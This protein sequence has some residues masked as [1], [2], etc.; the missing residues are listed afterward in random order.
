MAIYYTYTDESPAIATH[1]LLP[2]I[3]AFLRSENIE[4][5]TADISLASRV[6]ANFSEYLSEAQKT[7]DDLAFLANLTKSSDANIIK[8]P[9]ISASLPQLKACISELQARGY[10]LPNY[11]DNAQS[12]EEKSIKARYAKVLGSAVNPVLREGNSDRRAAKSVKDYARANPVWSAQWSGSE[13]T[14]VASMSGGDFYASEKSKI[15]ANSTNLSINFTPNGGEKTCLKTL[16]IEAG[17][18]VDSAFMSVSEL[19]NF[20]AASAQ[21]AKESGLVYSAHLKATM[22]K[23][24]D[25]VIFGRFVSV[26]FGGVFAEF[27]DEFK[28]L[29]INANDGLKAVFEKIKNSPNFAQIKDRFDEAFA[30]LP[31]IY[32]ID[33]NTTNFDMPN[34]VI[35]D[36]SM[37]AMIRN[38]GKLRTKG[39][40]MREAM[41]AIPDRSYAKIYEAMIEDLRAHGFLDPAKIG[42][43]ANVGLMAQK[44]E[45]YG[46]HDKTFIKENDGRIEVVSENG[47]VVFAYDLQKGDIFRM[48]Q[49]KEKAIKN[50]VNLA[51]SRAKI[52][53]ERLIFWLDEARAHDRNI[54]EILLSQIAKNAEFKGAN[55]EILDP[56][57]AVIKTNEIIRSGQNVISA[58]GNILRD[59]LTDLYPILELGSSAK[60]LSIV[61][62]LEGGAMFE[63]GAG[64]TAPDLVA[65]MR[66]QNH[67]SWDSLGEFMALCEALEFVAQKEQNKKA[68][69]LAN[70]LNAAIFRYLNEAKSPSR[71]VG[72][73][74]IRASHYFLAKFWAEELAKFEPKFEQIYAKFSENEAE[75]LDELNA[76][77]GKGV[78]FGGYFMLEFDKMQKIMRPSKILNKIIEEI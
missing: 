54:K 12:D 58:T 42:A 24:S 50:W 21:K 31:E 29:G 76:G 36:A 48:T 17:E 56:Y 69:T 3:K 77:Q 49:T 41:A 6:L 32:H 15:F 10:A 40:Q 39:G 37:P 7:S 44:A 74:D 65:M 57:E 13:Q 47:E 4:V 55:F 28:S 71:E 5:K 38:G 26:L 35:I 33:E 16:K 53:G 14:C 66:E 78:D 62:L 22:M 45:E 20:I 60:M 59:Y 70:A 2:I 72:Q 75:I 43:V 23:V 67:L 9:N 64:G 19:D 8:L 51:F 68:K 18:V 46:S 11:P 61:P 25:P 1:S 30:N 63:T 27:E 34:L 52:S 73:N